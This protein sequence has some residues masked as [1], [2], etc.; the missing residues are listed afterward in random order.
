MILD[1]DEV[2]EERQVAR[3]LKQILDGIAFLHSLNVAHLDI[4][5]RFPN[6]FIYIYIYNAK[7]AYAKAV[8]VRGASAHP[9]SLRGKRAKAQTLNLVISP[10]GINKYRAVRPL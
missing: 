5:V 9:R 1:R 3:L 8:N 4:K 7:F 10:R 6:M 2:P